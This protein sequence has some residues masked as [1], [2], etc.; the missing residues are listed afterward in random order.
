M[1][2]EIAKMTAR[3]GLAS[4]A[5]PPGASFSSENLIAHLSNR[6]R[7]L[8]KGMIRVPEPPN[9]T[10]IQRDSSSSSIGPLDAVPTEVIFMVLS[11][12]DFQSLSRLSRVSLRARILVQATPEYCGMMQHA[13][14]TLVALSRTRLIALHSA[15][16]L[17]STLKSERCVS[18]GEYGPFLF[19]PTCQR[20]CRLCLRI[21]RSLWV[22]PIS[23]ACKAFG[24]SLGQIRRL[25][26]MHSIPNLYSVGKPI[27]RRK[28]LRM[29]SVRAAKELALFIYGD[30]TSAHFSSIIQR[31]LEQPTLNFKLPAYRLL[32]DAPLE[33]FD[34]DPL[35]VPPTWS[36]DEY[37]GMATICFPSL[38]GGSEI[39]HGLWCR[40]CEWTSEHCRA[41]IMSPA[42][43]T[44]LAHGQD[45]ESYFLELSRRARS[46]AGFLEHVKSCYGA[47]KL[48]SMLDEKEWEEFMAFSWDS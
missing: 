12:L 21:N 38:L 48:L 10:N 42:T 30:D 28:P 16:L 34:R 29:V 41:Q 36:E 46:T 23:L 20:C 6:P 17:H 14:K 26:V 8:T 37:A 40:G 22:V 2:Y 32:Q 47:Q 1:H 7:H 27:S 4:S 19:L 39:E 11:N 45:P 31:A 5:T 3:R 24:L 33:P 35:R 43:A 9:P 25:A 13:P 44:S 15:A 18:C